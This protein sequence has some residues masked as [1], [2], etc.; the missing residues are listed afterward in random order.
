MHETFP[1]PFC[2]RHMLCL[3]LCV[4]CSAVR[5]SSE[6]RVKMRKACTSRMNW[7]NCHVRQ[8]QSVQTNTSHSTT[9]C[10]ENT[11]TD[12]HNVKLRLSK[13]SV[14]DVPVTEFHHIT[15]W[16]TEHLSRLSTSS[17]LMSRSD[18]PPVF[19]KLHLSCYI[20]Q[21]KT[22]TKTGQSVKGN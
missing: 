6:S 18:F 5:K 1:W 4:T 10:A 15:I 14:H 9:L 21:A 7:L 16:L 20:T 12:T 17:T 11:H 19:I 2:V 3:H 13:T 8:K 22:Q